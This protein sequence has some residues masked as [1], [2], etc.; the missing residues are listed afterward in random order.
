M[1][2]VPPLTKSK[3]D[4]SLLPCSLATTPDLHHRHSQPII[5]LL[6]LY[7]RPCNATPQAE[8]GWTNTKVCTHTHTHIGVW[9]L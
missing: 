8:T 6:K 4:P 1:V 2:V 3:A 9:L 5:V 7:L